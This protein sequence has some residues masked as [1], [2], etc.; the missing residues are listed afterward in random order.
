MTA[1]LRNLCEAAWRGPAEYQSEYIL[2][3]SKISDIITAKAKGIGSIRGQG[4]SE[5]EDLV[6]ISCL[7]NELSALRL[8][9][10]SNEMALGWLDG[11]AIRGD[12]DSSDVQITVPANTTQ[13]VLDAMR[14]GN[15]GFSFMLPVSEQIEQFLSDAGRLIEAGR[16]LIEPDRLIFYHEGQKNENGG[17][18]WHGLPADVVGTNFK[19]WRT[20]SEL[21]EEERG[22]PTLS[23]QLITDSV[24]S[25]LLATELALPVLKGVPLREYALILEDES[26]ILSEFRTEMRSFSILLAS[27]EKSV[28]DLRDDVLGPRL[29]K[30]DRSFRRISRMKTLNSAGAA[31]ATC[32]LVITA[33]ATQG[34]AAA[35]AAA[36]GSAGFIK[37]LKEWSDGQSK[38]DELRDEPAYLLWK[39]KHSSPA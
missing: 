25:D 1:V 19:Q 33:V 4:I 31:V 13:N 32:A 29:A 30:I 20:K 3:F 8:E 7:Y 35:V 28:S 23:D 9:L 39:F 22:L 26:D 18:N 15:I 38:L 12:T 24:Q 16:L 10:S 36:A 27:G 21:Q 11:A 17:T 34:T 14:A 6:K 5:I 37:S 2:N